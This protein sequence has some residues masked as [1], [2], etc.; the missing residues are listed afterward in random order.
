MYNIEKHSIYKR[1]DMI[2]NGRYRLTLLQ[3]RIILYAISH[4]K[5]DDPE[6]AMYE[7]KL[8]DLYKVA[9]MAEDSYTRFKET[10]QKLDSVNW[11]INKNGK[12]ILGRWFSFIEVDPEN[13][14]ASF[15]F[16]RGVA[17][18]LFDLVRQQKYYTQYELENI[19]PMTHQ[20]SPRL[21]E[22][23]KSYSKNNSSWCFELDKFKNL[24]DCES[25][26]LWSDIR[27]RILDPSIEEINLK[28]DLQVS[29][30]PLKEGKK[31]IGIKFSFLETDNE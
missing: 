8:K 30:T 17:P 20:A 28:T 12:E 2:Q 22:I 5:A 1:D 7:F 24:M 16:H 23:L 18:F 21:Y 29:Y 19:L 6:N 27:R 25:Y 15:Q 26:K 14:T 13:N 9:G 4:I 31:V 11:W 3:Q 10:I